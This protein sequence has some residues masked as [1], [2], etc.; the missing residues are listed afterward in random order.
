[1]CHSP[2]GVRICGFYQEGA[3]L[4]PAELALWIADDRLQRAMRLKLRAKA[5]ECGLD[6]D[7]T[8]PEDLDVL[9]E[10]ERRVDGSGKATGGDLIALRDYRHAVNSLL[11][12]MEQEKDT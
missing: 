8:L 1:M 6:P 7:T 10:T 5:V 3:E 12:K 2:H 11:E 9:D 4:T